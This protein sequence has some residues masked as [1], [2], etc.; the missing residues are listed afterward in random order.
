MSGGSGHNFSEIYLHANWHYR[1]DEPLIRPEIRGRLYEIIEEYCRKVKGIHFERLGGTENHVHLV[2]QMEPFVL[3]SDFIGKVKGASAHEVNKESGPET[4]KWQRGYGVVSFSKK[5]LPSVLSY[6]E[7]QKKHHQA[8]T[9]TRY[10]RLTGCSEGRGKTEVRF[11]KPR[12]S[13]LEVGVS[14]RASFHPC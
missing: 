2:F 1:N 8:G 12:S 4:I 9:T 10:W 3:L 6:V 11:R 7:N 5:H 14:V 13:A